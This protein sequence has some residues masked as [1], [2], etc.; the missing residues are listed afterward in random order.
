MTSRRDRIYEA[1]PRTCEWIFQ[2]PSYASWINN[3]H[4]TLWIKGKP[5]SGKSTLLKFLRQKCQD[6]LVLDFFFSERGGMRERSSISMFQTFLYQLFIKEKA[7]RSLV[8]VAYQEKISYDRDWHLEELEG[9]FRQAVIHTATSRAVTIFVD[10]LDEAEMARDLQSYFRALNDNLEFSGG[11]MK[12][13]ISCRHYPVLAAIQTLE[14]RMEDESYGDISV[15]VK[16]RLGAVLLD[17]WHGCSI[18]ECE[19]LQNE[20]IQRSSGM[21]VWVHVVIN[22]VIRAFEEGETLTNIRE[23][24]LFDT[25]SELMHLYGYILHKV[26]HRLKALHLMQWISLAERPLSVTELRCALTYDDTASYGKGIRYLKNDISMERLVTTLSGGLIEVQQGKDSNDNRSKL[27]QFIHQSVRDFLIS[28]GLNQLGGPLSVNQIIGQG[29]DRLCRS[30][31]K[32]LKREEMLRKESMQERDRIWLLLPFIGY[33]S[34]HWSQHAEHADRF[35]FS[36]RDLVQQLGSSPEVTFN[37]WVQRHR[38]IDC[39]H[40]DAICPDP[41]FPFYLPAGDIEPGKSG[42]QKANDDDNCAL[43]YASHWGHT[44]LVNM[45]LDAGAGLKAKDDEGSTALEIASANGHGDVV[46]LLLDRGADPNESTGTKGNAL[47]SAALKGHIKVVKILLESGAG[48]NTCG[49]KYHTALQ[50]AAYGGRYGGSEAVVRLLLDRGA[51]VNVRGGHFGTALQAAA[52]GGNEAVV[53]LL[54][55]HNAGVNIGAGEYGTALQAAALTGSERLTQLLLDSGA[56]VNT[57]RGRYC[58]ALQAAASTGQE[59]VTRLLLQRGAKVNTQGGWFGSALQAAGYGGNEAVVRLLLD[60]GGNIK[61]QGGRYCTALQAAAFKASAYGG[62]DAVVRVL[63]DRGAD[64]GA[65]GGQYGTAL[66]AARGH[67]GTNEAVVE[68]LLEREAQATPVLR[69]WPPLYGLRES[70]LWKPLSY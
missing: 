12:I 43:H 15:Y 55:K 33:A 8:K 28:D 69:A 14:V 34:R 24:L 2:H 50:A 46:R 19:S 54:L 47:Q 30:C 42:Q 66:Q 5:G 59:A 53:S 41:G 58:T 32:Y 27:V 4:S 44:Y 57:Q 3:Q 11:A 18:Q 26:D 10:A 38:K 25:P 65:K 16:D 35:G 48:V 67:Y 23:R 52:Y 63:L 29:Q 61:M 36:Q 56:E 45:L 17:K 13:C 39:Y 20:I 22:S 49:G 51:E 31:V 40:S 1:H 62:S 7:V 68:L 60:K 21:F 6:D 37:V 9:L 64:L 70:K